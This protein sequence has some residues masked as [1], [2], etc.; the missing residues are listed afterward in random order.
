MDESRFDA[1]CRRVGEAASRRRALRL[2]LGLGLS[3]L[4]SAGGAAKNNTLGKRRKKRR[5]RCRKAGQT[6]V[7]F[8]QTLG[9]CCANSSCREV[10]NDQRQFC[11]CDPGF[12]DPN[13]DGF[14]VPTECGTLGEECASVEAC[15][16]PA[17]GGGLTCATIL[18]TKGP[19]GCGFLTQPD[20]PSRCCLGEGGA[21]C[22]GDCDCCGDM[23]CQ[24]G[25]CVRTSCR[26]VG[27]ACRDVNNRCCGNGSAA[28]APV[29]AKD[30]VLCQP[31]GT[32]LQC[33][34]FDGQ[35]CADSCECCGESRCRQGICKDLSSPGPQCK[36]LGATC[37]GYQSTECCGY[38]DTQCCAFARCDDDAPYQGPGFCRRVCRQ[39][40]E[41][42]NDGTGGPQ[43][44]CCAT[45]RC[46]DGV[47]ERQSG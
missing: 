15:C 22:T 21:I 30:D 1:L 13:R 12:W 4:L 3:P 8:G 29:A 39:L 35:P 5:R 20:P 47:C 19:R 28:C 24:N 37:L 45:F 31:E 36:E 25:R 11:L 41:A 16:P 42:C 7:S 9:P 23:A 10:P 17:L 26:E 32:E 44:Q 27:E 2:L 46:N 18:D 40:G 6:C 38:P 34:L 14:C 43:T 33:C